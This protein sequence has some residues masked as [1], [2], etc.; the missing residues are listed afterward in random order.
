MSEMETS[1]DS[2]LQT[3]LFTNLRLP[4]CFVFLSLMKNNVTATKNQ[5]DL[6]DITYSVVHLKHFKI[7]PIVFVVS[8]P[9]FYTSCIYFFE[10]KTTVEQKYFNFF[11]FGNHVEFSGSQK[12]QTIS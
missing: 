3:T 7:L 1:V 8:F 9:I 10:K 5:N 12:C 11:H 4:H 2:I 6:H